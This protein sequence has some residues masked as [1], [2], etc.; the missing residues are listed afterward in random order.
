MMKMSARINKRGSVKLFMT[1]LRFSLTMWTVTHAV[2]YVRLSTD[3]MIAMHCASPAVA[4]IYEAEILTGLTEYGES[5]HRDEFMEKSIQHIKSK[6][7]KNERP[8]MMKKIEYITASLLHRPS[9]SRAYEQFRTGSHHGGSKEE[10]RYHEFLS[11]DSVLMLL[12]Q[13]IHNKMQLWHHT[14]LP[15]VGDF[16]KAEKKYSTPEGLELPDGETLSLEVPRCF[17]TGTNRAIEYCQI[18]YIDDPFRQDRTEKD[19]A[20]TRILATTLDRKKE[21]QRFVHRE[22]SV[23]YCELDKSLDKEKL[24]EHI[25][26]TID[27]LIANDVEVDDTNSS[28]YYDNVMVRQ[29]NKKH[30]IKL[31]MQLRGDYFNRDKEARDRHES[32]ARQAFEEVYPGLSRANMISDLSSH[33]IYS[34]CDDVV[35]MYRQRANQSANN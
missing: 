4:A 31:L 11:A 29:L 1:A 30:R 32:I 24:G 8:G 6:T 26:S 28:H 27:W 19:V 9:Q 14:N 22:T 35:A 18:N 10:G 23:D 20:L 17:E 3:I 5:I 33:K 16:D 15:I 7:G 2:D 21:L 12:H 13:K 34:L 25:Q